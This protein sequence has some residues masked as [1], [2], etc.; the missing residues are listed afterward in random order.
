MTSLSWW[1]KNIARNQMRE[2]TTDQFNGDH[3][4]IEIK[5]E[6]FKLL[7]CKAFDSHDVTESCTIK[8]HFIV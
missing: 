3:L 2:E 4:K 6:A 1:R 8:N 5:V 7:I